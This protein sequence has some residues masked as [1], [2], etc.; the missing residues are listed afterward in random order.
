PRVRAVNDAE[1]DE[2]LATALPVL[3]GALLADADGV[4]LEVDR[5]TKAVAFASSARAPEVSQVGAPCPDHL[6]NTKHRPLAVDFDPDRDDAARLA[7]ALR[8]G[9]GDFAAWYRSYYEQNLTDESRPFPIDPAGP[10]VVL[11]PGIGVVTSGADAGRAR[12]ARD[13]YHRAIQ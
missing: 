10:R 4:V 1:A 7:A 2:L 11:L 5:S 13:L 9:S 12:F 6:S 3:R 8:E